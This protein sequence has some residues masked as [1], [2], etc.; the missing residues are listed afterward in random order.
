MLTPADVMLGGVLPGLVAAAALAGVWKFTKNAASGWR[1]AVVVSFLIGM[2]ALDAQGAG[3]VT[4]I[5]KSMRVTEARDFLALMVILAVIP[6]AVAAVGYRGAVVGWVLRLGLCVFVPW[7]LLWGSRFLP[8]VAPPPNFDTGAWEPLEAVL[9][10]GGWAGA[11]LATWAVVRA[12]STESPHLRSAL[13]TLAVFAASA[14]VAMSGSLTYGQVAG[15]LVATVAG[16]ALVTWL[17]KVGRGPDA[18]AG[19]IVIAFGGVVVLAHFFAE[20]T[21]LHAVLLLAGLAI[22]GGWF[23]PGKK[24]SVPVRCLVCLLAIGCA[25]GTAGMEFIAAQASNPYSNL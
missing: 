2:W 5:S 22:G 15:V 12:E 10:I 13:A 24:W 8:K 20:L 21:L 11:L 9:W 18:A 14:T 19:P 23:F 25:V 4:A 6:D 1:T 3:V 17:L 7:R 16:C